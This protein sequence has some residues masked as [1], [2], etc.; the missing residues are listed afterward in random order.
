MIRPLVSDPSEPPP[1]A[2]HAKSAQPLQAGG[3]VALIGLFLIS[4]ALGALIG[5]QPWLTVFCWV[6]GLGAAATRLPRRIGRSGDGGRH[7]PTLRPW[8]LKPRA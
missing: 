4:A 3:V 2:A 5:D 7:W 8:R 1:P 6:V